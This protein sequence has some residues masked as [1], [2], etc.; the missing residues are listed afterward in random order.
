[1]EHSHPSASAS[2]PCWIA[3]VTRPSEP[4]SGTALLVGVVATAYFVF[5]AFHQDRDLFPKTHD[6]SS[7]LLGMQMLAHGRLWMPKH[8][9]AD[10][11]ET[12]YV[13]VDPVYASKYFPRHRADVRADDLAALADVGAARRRQRRD[14]RLLYRIIT[15]L[16]DGVAGLLAAILMA[17][18]SWFRMLSILLFSQ[19]PMLLLGLLVVWAWLRWRD[20][21]RFGWLIAIGAFAGWGAITRPVD[22]LVFAAA[23]GV[24]MLCSLWRT[25]AKRWVVAAGWVVL[26]A[27][28]FLTV[29]LI[30]N[31]GVTGHVLQ[32][33]FAYYIDR[34]HPQTSFGFHDYD[35][36]DGAASSLPQKRDYYR[37]VIAPLVQRHRIGNLLHNWV[38]RDVPGQPAYDRPRLPMVVD[39]TMPFRV[40]L[41]IAFVGLPRL[42][43][44]PP[45]GAVADVAAVHPRVRSVHV[46]PRALRRQRRPGGDPEHR[47]RRRSAG[48]D[49]AAVRK[50]DPLVVRAW[51]GH[52]RLALDVRA[53]P[54][55]HAARP[56]SRGQSNSH[57]IDDETFHS[58]FLRAVN[59]Q[60]PDVI[61]KPAVILFR[62]APGQNVI[63]EP[64]Y[65]N[66][67]AWPDDQEIVRAH[68]F[69]D[70]R[71]IQIVQYYA[72]HQPDRVFY[73]FDRATMTLSPPLGTARQLLAEMQQRGPT[74][75]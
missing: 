44:R 51:R 55:L 69:G 14:R 38:R 49:V 7:Y 46:F 11:F 36:R 15:Q 17:S 13:I 30:F 71:N 47:P 9:L 64:V 61:Q 20:K 6:E 34:D 32:T 70:G 10:F 4:S 39:S 41:P 74:T 29:Q 16:A 24:G 2:P 57:V 42:D 53:Q 12:F 67:A 63:E 22:A 58:N 33:P 26:G 8:P 1:L 35:P 21:P 75:R 40:L 65:N 37:N 62:Y 28:P 43:R 45:A 60:I 5:T 52:A 19:V 27:A 31:K 25:A 68:D 59:T 54:H 56:R 48:D 18:L 72:E 23:V 66:L 50:C 3:F 73:R